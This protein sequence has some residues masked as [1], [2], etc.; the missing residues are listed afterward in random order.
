MF[1][2]PITEFIPRR[3]LVA[4]F[5][6]AAV[7]VL[8]G[9][10][11]LYGGIDPA[12]ALGVAVSYAI[13]F[14]CGIIFYGV[15]VHYLKLYLLRSIVAATVLVLSLGLTGGL[16]VFLE[17]SDWRGYFR[18]LPLL[19]IYGSMGWKILALW[20]SDRRAGTP[21][22]E[23]EEETAAPSGKRETIDRIS[24]RKGSEIH[25]IKTEELFYI[26]ADG[27]YV[28][29]FTGTGKYLKEQTMKYF[30]EHLPDHFIRIHR[31]C[32][33]NV[34]EITR[35]ELFGK[36]NYHVRL[37]NGTVLK[38]SVTGYRLLKERLRL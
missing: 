25:L 9:L 21:P 23:P 1:R 29:L 33:V 28:W 12:K 7:A 3:K 38:A 19:V 16:A 11:T 5:F 24:V 20:F 13:L 2:H 18:I 4:L 22:E 31:S 37:R 10:V 6:V 8:W 15:T 32:I 26:Q 17:W 27:D 14:S 30:G 35:V 36:E 34:D